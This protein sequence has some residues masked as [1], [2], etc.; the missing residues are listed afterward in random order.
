MHAKSLLSWLIL[1]NL[2]DCSSPAPLSMGF[3]RQECWRGLLCPPLIR[4]WDFPGKNTGVGCCF[5]L[6]GIFPIQGLNP[7]LPHCRQMLYHL[8]HQ[9]SP[10]HRSLGSFKH[11]QHIKKQTHHFAN[12]GPCSQSYCFS[13]SHV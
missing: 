4:P 3:L 12:K 9:R 13:S 7:G 8:S 10:P 5:L 6:Q 2:R 11:I 1:G